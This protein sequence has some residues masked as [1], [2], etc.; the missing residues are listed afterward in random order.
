MK[1]LSAQILRPGVFVAMPMDMDIA[2]AYPVNQIVRLRVQGV[3]K[4]RSVLQLN[5]YWA[6]CQTVADNTDDPQWNTKLKVDFQCRVGCHFVDP[7][8]VSVKKD[9]T[10][11]FFYRSIA[12]KNLT[13]IG[14]CNYFGRAFEHMA[15]FLGCTVDAFLEQAQEG[16]G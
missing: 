14:A 10:V 2:K 12:F 6:C 4:R 5:T 3:K 8:L 16:M 7:D 11:V 13:H 15:A 1:E 9:G